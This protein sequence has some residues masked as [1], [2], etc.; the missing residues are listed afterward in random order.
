M[1]EPVKI[2]NLVITGTTSKVELDT[3]ALRPIIDK[4]PP[5]VGESAPETDLDSFIFPTEMPS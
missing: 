5:N 2:N 3:S 1:T 4:T